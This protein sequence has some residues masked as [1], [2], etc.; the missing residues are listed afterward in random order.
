[1]A[2]QYAARHRIHTHTQADLLDVTI[3]NNLVHPYTV[4]MCAQCT[5]IEQEE[6][7]NGQY[8]WQEPKE[9]EAGRGRQQTVLGD[10]CTVSAHCTQ[11]HALK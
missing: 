7:Y 8:E 1:M 2:L 4:Y 10:K 6:A 9:H 3:P 5:H 11:W